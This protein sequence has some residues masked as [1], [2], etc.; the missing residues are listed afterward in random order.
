MKPFIFVGYF[1]NS[2]G[3]W[4]GDLLVVDE[5]QYGEVQHSR[6]IHGHRSKEV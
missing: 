5:V 6:D 1:L 2:G 4:S 3:K